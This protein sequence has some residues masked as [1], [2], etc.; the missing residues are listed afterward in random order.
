MP[1]H[2]HQLTH[3]AHLPTWPFALVRG[4]HASNHATNVG[5]KPR[6]NIGGNSHQLAHRRA[7]CNKHRLPPVGPRFGRTVWAAG[8]PKTASP[9]LVGPAP[10]SSQAVLQPRRGVAK[11]LPAIVDLGGLQQS[12]LAKWLCS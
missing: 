6:A 1:P 11:A 5:C 4:W 8:L 3:C 2:G 12:T 7:M 10:P 9:R